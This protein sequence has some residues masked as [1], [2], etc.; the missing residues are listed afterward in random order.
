VIRSRLNEPRFNRLLIGGL[1]FIFVVLCIAYNLALPLFEAPDEGAH[2]IYV[3][4][5]ASHRQLPDLEHMLSHEVS[6]TPLYY[7][8]GAPLIAWIDRSDFTKVFRIETGLNNGIVN[9]HTPSEHAFP[10]TGVTL[11]VR[12]LR[13][14]STLLGALTALL[15]YATVN[16]LFVRRDVALV[17]LAV[18]AFNPKFLHLSSQFNND[19]ALACTSALCVWIA[20]RML[21]QAAPPAWKQWLVL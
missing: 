13:L 11:A 3:D 9:A 21:K 2:Y 7:I 19:I 18:T 12:I 8:I 6:Q 14:Y 1:L 10:P 17:A 5:I 16:T 20:A 15:V 4:Y